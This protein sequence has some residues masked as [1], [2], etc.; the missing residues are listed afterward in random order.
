MYFVKLVILPTFMG[1]GIEPGVVSMTFS[2]VLF[3]ATLPGKHLWNWKAKFGQSVFVRMANE[4]FLPESFVLKLILN[5][6]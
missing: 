4:S 6:V 1:L 5:S 3:P 2:L